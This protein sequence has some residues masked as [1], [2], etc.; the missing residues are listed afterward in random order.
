MKF[1]EEQALNQN[2]NENTFLIF[3]GGQF[4]GPYFKSLNIYFIFIFLYTHTP[5]L[6]FPLNSQQIL[7]IYY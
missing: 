4:I 7:N 1:N 2:L 6:P 5:P 3:L